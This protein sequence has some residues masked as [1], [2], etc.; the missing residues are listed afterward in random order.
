MMQGGLQKRKK[1]ARDFQLGA[2]YTLPKPSE[3]PQEYSL[4]PRPIAHQKESD[5]CTQFMAC[6]MS[7][8][9]EHTE[10]S[11]EFAFALSK[12]LS[13]DPDAWGQDIRVALKVHTKIGALEKSQATLSLENVDAKILRYIQNWPEYNG[14]KE[15][16]A[17]HKKSGY[18][19]VY[20]R[21]LDAFDAIRGALWKFR[22]EERAVGIGV[23]FGWSLEDKLLNTVPG[24]GFGHA[25]TA[26]GFGEYMGRDVIRV[27]N[28]YGENVGDNGY[29][30][31][32]R[33][34]INHFAEIYGLYMFADLP[35]DKETAIAHSQWY[36]AGVL[37]KI[38]LFFSDLFA[39]FKMIFG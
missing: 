2:F 25:M 5:F 33:E 8:F 38:F 9:Q 20:A 17:Q 37:K 36:R 1:D 7:S 18:F 27:Q 31:F 29:H 19:E 13:G 28:S 6:L 24:K 10:L 14:L 22:D 15:K 23:L 26:V 34:V 12:E 3:L 30:Y 11:P 21:G 16:C 32:T 35:V 4:P 39:P